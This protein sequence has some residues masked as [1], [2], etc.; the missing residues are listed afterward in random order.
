MRSQLYLNLKSQLMKKNKLIITGKSYLLI[1]LVSLVSSSF[2]F[3]QSIGLPSDENM[4][5]LP[6]D[7]SNQVVELNHEAYYSVKDTGDVIHTIPSNSIYCQGLTWDGNNLW[8]SEI[9]SGK[10]YQVDPAY[11]VVIKTFDAPGTSTE[12]L[13]WDGTYLWASDNGGGPFEPSYIYKLD[14][15]DGSIISSFVPDGVWIHGITWDG[16]YLWMV[17]FSDDKIIKVDSETGTNVHIIDA[18]GAA[19]VGLAWD[20]EHLWTDDF[21]TD[22]LYCINP[23]D[24]AVIYEVTSPHTN[25]RDLTWDGD[26]LWVM[27]SASSIIYKVDVGYNTSIGESNAF[28]ENVGSISVSPNPISEYALISYTIHQKEN[29]QLQLYNSN[30]VLIRILLN[31][32]Q[33]QGTYQLKINATDLMA[34]AY[35][36]VLQTDQKRIVCKMIKIE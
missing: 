20:G 2:V 36:C 14:P 23:T 30:G 8:Y 9:V 26:Y 3:S 21:E 11:G 18:P 19:C 27:A 29:I 4:D 32:D 33:P 6:D 22:K 16:Q 28:S 10:I 31:S 15:A 13:A 24:G 34:G 5:F 17:D 25:P 7:I 1:V 35:Y 12:G